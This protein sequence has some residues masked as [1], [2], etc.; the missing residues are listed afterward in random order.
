MAGQGAEKI[1]GSPQTLPQSP[2]HHKEW[3]VACKG[4]KPA[5]SHFDYA[6]VLTETVLLGNVA[7]R[8]GKKIEWDGP[9]LRATNCP[10]ANAYLQRSYRKGWS[11]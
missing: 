11:L 1:E 7:I 2:G 6:G 10:E 8:V 5:L 4:G 3:V 9:S